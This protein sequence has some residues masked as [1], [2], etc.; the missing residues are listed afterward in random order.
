METRAPEHDASD[1]GAQEVRILVPVRRSRERQP[2]CRSYGR[3][4]RPVRVT[5]AGKIVATRWVAFPGVLVCSLR[6]KVNKEDRV[7]RERFGSEQ[8]AYA[9]RTRY[10]LD[11]PSVLAIGFGSTFSSVTLE[12]LSFISVL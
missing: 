2:Q 11:T 1:T 9:S 8:D 6:V 4:M 7:L 3:K 12:E 10:R 5:A